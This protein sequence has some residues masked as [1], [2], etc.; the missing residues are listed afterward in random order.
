MD[1]ACHLHKGFRAVSVAA[2]FPRLSFPNSPPEKDKHHAEKESPG[3]SRSQ[4]RNGDAD[5]PRRRSR[6]ARSRDGNVTFTTNYMVRG[7]TQTELQACTSRARSSTVTRAACIAGLFGVQRELARETR[8]KS[9]DLQ[10][11]GS[12]YGGAPDNAISSS[13][14]I[15]LYV[16]FRNKFAGDFSYDVGAVYYYYPGTYNLNTDLLARPYE[17]Q[18]RRGLR[19]HRLEVAH[20]Q[21]L[22][23]SDRRRVHG[24]R[25]AG[26]DLHQPVGD[27]AHRR[28]GLQ[29]HRRTWEP[30]CGLARPAYLT[31]LGLDNGIY[32]AVDYK[33]G[34]TK[35]LVGFTWGAV[36][37]GQHGDQ[38]TFGRRRSR[39]GR[40]G[41]PL[42][43]EHR[44]ATLSSCPVTKSF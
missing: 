11:V 33:V 36:L 40:L 10:A 31:S 34:V 8:G 14:E 16:G 27:G 21:G 12:A 5:R 3:R 25:C 7:V 2:G 19:R 9:A 23:R 37:L 32:D 26:H 4:P 6:L 39:D 13:L 20:R 44:R 28:V 24:A 17:G 29:R 42:R 1:Q 30:G 43:Q 41:Q 35:D 18:Y 22:V 38:T 15:D